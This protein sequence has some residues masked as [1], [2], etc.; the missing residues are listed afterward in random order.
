LERDQNDENEKVKFFVFKHAA[1]WSEKDEAANR[2]A[3]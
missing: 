1:R 2:A 3:V